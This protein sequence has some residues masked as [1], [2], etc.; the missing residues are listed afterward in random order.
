VSAGGPFLSAGV[1]KGGPEVIVVGLDPHKKTHTAMAVDQAGRPVGELTF[2]ARTKGFERLLSW[3]RELD[4]RR[5]F[6]VEDCRHVSSSFERFLVGHGEQG[7]R[8]PPKLMAGARESARTAG[9][10]DPIDALAVARAALREP[11]LP[12]IGL[13]GAELDLRLLVDHREDLVAQR[14]AVEQRLRWHLH[15]LDPALE[16]PARRLGVAAQLQ[17]VDR[18]LARMPKTTRARIAR[19]L[20]SQCKLLSAEID[21]LENEIAAIVRGLAPELLAIPGCGSLTAAK[22]VGEIGD[23]RRFS[24]DAK[25][26]LHAGVAPLPASSGNSSR[27]RL[28]RKGNRQLN[29]ALHRI[30]ITQARI[31]DPAR[32]YLARKQAEGKTHREALR[33]LKRF[34]AREIYNTLTKRHLNANTGLTAAVA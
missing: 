29:V 8:V 20:V 18:K 13:E 10:S 22:L 24:S 26:A 28:N 34:I 5:L 2:P 23:V 15:D 3:A 31:H 19:R 33:C 32:T 4:E 11:D 16:V 27:Y 1:S 9:K 30:A 12:R 17:R 14:T 6:A 7:V 21:A 25:L